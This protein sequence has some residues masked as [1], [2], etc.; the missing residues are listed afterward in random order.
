MMFFRL[1]V[2]ILFR[3]TFS[4]V[5]SERFTL[6]AIGQA[7]DCES[8]SQIFSDLEEDMVQKFG[9]H[10]KVIILAESESSDGVMVQ[11]SRVRSTYLITV[12]GESTAQGV[13][14]G[15]DSLRRYVYNA[16]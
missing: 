13:A 2:A 16:S 1:L 15:L 11:V 5:Q 4:W 9:G 3:K 6:L 14:R 12:F 10:V 7:A 8:V